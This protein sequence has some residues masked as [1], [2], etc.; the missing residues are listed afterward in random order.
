[1]E[2]VP[3]CQRREASSG[4]A[5]QGSWHREP[6]TSWHLSAMIYLKMRGLVRRKKRLKK[7]KPSLMQ[8][9]HLKPMTCSLNWW[10]TASSAV[11]PAEGVCCPHRREQDPWGSVIV[12]THAKKQPT[13]NS[14]AEILARARP[15]PR[16]SILTHL[17]SH[18]VVFIILMNVLSEPQ[19][20]GWIL[21]EEE[22]HSQCWE[23]QPTRSSSL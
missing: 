6:L 3:V 9:F 8:M 22:S 5:G 17:I 4:S 7:L 13:V 16:Y 12:P 19:A 14:Q 23:A 2:Y 11:S 15:L 20:N 10:V 1:M 18:L 21:Y